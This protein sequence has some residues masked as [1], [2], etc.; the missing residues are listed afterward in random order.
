VRRNH[1]LSSRVGRIGEKV[2]FRWIHQ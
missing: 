1:R 2:I